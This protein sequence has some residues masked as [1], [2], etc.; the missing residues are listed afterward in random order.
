MRRSTALVAAASLTVVVACT[1]LLLMTGG[2]DEGGDA[3]LKPSSRQHNGAPIALE[4]RSRMQIPRSTIMSSPPSG[5]IVGFPRAMRT[6]AAAAGYEAGTR[7]VVDDGTKWRPIAL[8]AMRMPKIVPEL[9]GSVLRRT[10]VSTDAQG[11]GEGEGEE[12][13]G[14]VERLRSEASKLRSLEKRAASPL[15]ERRHDDGSWYKMRRRGRSWSNGR[16][17]SLFLQ[18]GFEDGI[19]YLPDNDEDVRAKVRDEDRERNATDLSSSCATS[20]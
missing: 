6:L 8:S 7:A 17:Q 1:V 11:E 15:G 18:D 2:M 19:D 4:Q 5:V 14:E 10:V 12:G 16:T 3:S 13:A 9:R 20:P